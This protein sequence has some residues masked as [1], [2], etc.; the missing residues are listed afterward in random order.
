MQEKVSNMSAITIKCL[1]IKTMKIT[2]YKVVILFRKEHLQED[3][4][5]KEGRN[6]WKF[7]FTANPH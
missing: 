7:C 6:L 4:H 1:L 2:D 3:S 5:M